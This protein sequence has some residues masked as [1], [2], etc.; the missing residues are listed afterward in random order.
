MK[1]VGYYAICAPDKSSG[2]YR[3]IEGI[4]SASNK[5]G[6]SAAYTLIDSGRGSHFN[7]A[8]KVG[9]AN[10]DVIIVRGNSYGFF[11]LMFG[12]I[13]ARVRGKRVVLD[14]A[15]PMGAV[16]YEIWDSA[17]TFSIKF[18]KTFGWMLSGPWSFW[19]ANRVMQYAPENKWFSLGLKK[20]TILI[21]N[22]VNVSSIPMRR[23][24]PAW[25]NKYLKLIGVAQL[26]SWHG[27]DL[28][29]KAI[30]EFNKLS[31]KKFDI[32][33]VIIG[34][35]DELNSL[36]Q[37]TKNL[38]LCD[39]VRFT[40][41]LQGDKLYHEYDGAHIAISSLALH[42]IGLNFASVLKAREYCAIG[43]PFLAAGID[44]D[45]SSDIDF[46]YIV[47]LSEDFTQIVDFFR[48]LEFIDKFKM[49][50]EIREFS[51]AKLDLQIK[52]KSFLEI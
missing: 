40:G 17:S 3:K 36:K 46:R 50:E 44:P 48:K 31:D 30:S 26:S 47:D 37:L 52:V 41:S 51:E 38:S 2:V 43:I 8:S 4:V 32:N 28:I 42:R 15:T 33:F 10:E 24:S 29:I 1:T 49:P 22:G 16:F 12:L 34:S 45:F 21:G 6:Y 13:F 35:G 7:L 19:A 18:F 5:L 20:K 25:P 23:N 9:R 39:H 14:V 11:I 27:Y